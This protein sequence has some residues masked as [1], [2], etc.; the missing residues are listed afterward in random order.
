MRKILAAAVGCAAALVALPAS[1]T[2]L[3][4]DG[5]SCVPDTFI[6][7]N[8]LVDAGTGATVT[9]A[10]GGVGV[11]FDSTN[12][13]L[14]KGD[15]N[16][17]ADVSST[18]GLLN[19]LTFAIENGYTFDAAIF[20]LFPI[21]GN[22]PND[23]FTPLKADTVVISYYA[24]GLGQQSLTISTNG[25]N[26]LGIYGNAGEKFTSVGF[27]ADPSTNGIQDLRQLRLAGISPVQSAVPEPSTWAMLLVG[28]GAIGAS[29]R[30]RKPGSRLRLR[31][32]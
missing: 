9:G 20:N 4:C 15:A 2:V 1:A 24:P 5:A 23:P 19:D 26:F 28:F 27:A 11:T 3:I 21:S 12:D 10:V 16:G 14:L 7:S 25:Q 30:R 32:A 22:N 17:Q 18:D 13:A 31:A 6:F 8:V 29:L